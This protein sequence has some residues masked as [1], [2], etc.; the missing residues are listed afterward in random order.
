MLVPLL[1]ALPLGVLGLAMPPKETAAPD[2]LQPRDSPPK[3]EVMTMTCLMPGDEEPTSI[4][5]PPDWS[6]SYDPDWSSSFTP[7]YPPWLS[8]SSSSSSDEG[9]CE[10][11]GDC[12]FATS[13]S[14]STEDG[15]PWWSSASTS[16]PY[17]DASSSSDFFTTSSEV[18][19]P[20]APY[21]WS[22]PE[23]TYTDWPTAETSSPSPS[24]SSTTCDDWDVWCSYTATYNSDSSSSSSPSFP[25]SSASDCDGF[26][27]GCSQ[28]DDGG[29]GSATLTGGTGDPE[30]TTIS[31]RRRRSTSTYSSSSVTS[32]PV[33]IVGP[34]STVAHHLPLP[35]MIGHQAPRKRGGAPPPP[36]P[37]RPAHRAHRAPVAPRAGAAGL[38]PQKRPSTPTTLSER[39]RNIR[40]VEK[41][42]TETIVIGV[43]T[44]GTPLYT[45]TEWGSDD[46]S[47]SSI[48]SSSFFSPATT[49]TT[50]HTTTSASSVVTPAPQWVSV[51]VSGTSTSIRCDDEFCSD[52]SSWC[53]YWAGITSWDASK[54]PVPGEKATIIGT[55]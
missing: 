36:P 19:D 31:G 40:A 33:T 1:L 24:P 15:W 18:S 39:I 48:P 44:D 9:D 20:C 21:G 3:V 32:S 2:R 27:F 12:P 28:T 54:G 25:T 10:L 7:D 8:S 5:S 26:M 34:M 4:P 23:S 45:S 22:C 51:S 13:T 17:P 53:V 38:P 41:I 55:C 43:S 16:A 14:T 11:W 37:R 30:T 46:S 29:F 35:P 47:S 49:S 52:G 6:S 50:Q 42:A